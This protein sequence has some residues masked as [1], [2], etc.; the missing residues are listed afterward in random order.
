[1]NL[2]YYLP[3]LVNLIKMINEVKFPA[4]DASTNIVPVIATDGQPTVEVTNLQYA[5][6]P[7]SCQSYIP[8]GGG[9]ILPLE[10]I[11]PLKTLPEN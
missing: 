7:G 10:T 3:S 8:E 11:L 9:T 6:I 2:L 4:D 5:C 1:M